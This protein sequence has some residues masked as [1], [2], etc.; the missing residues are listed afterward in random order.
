MIPS[1]AGF[2]GLL[3]ACIADNNLVVAAFQGVNPEAL[4][5][6]LEAAGATVVEPTAQG[7]LLRVPP[8]A[9]AA[10]LRVPGVFAAELPTLVATEADVSD[11]SALAD[12]SQRYTAWLGTLRD[13]AAPLWLDTPP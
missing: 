2:T 1:A 11:R 8:A 13:G 9:A 7:F 4:R 6:G 5:P 10:V 12:H 3:A